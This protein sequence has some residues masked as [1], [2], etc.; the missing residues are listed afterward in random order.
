MRIG[1]FGGT[2]DPIHIGHIQLANNATKD[3]KLNK[4]F[5]VP[6]KIPPHKVS[7]NLLPV[8]QRLEMIS[9]AIKTNKAFSIS[10]YEINRKNTTYTYQTVKYFKNKYPNDEIFLLLGSDSLNDL[11]SWKHPEILVSLCKF[12]VA[13]RK[14]FS[15]FR[16]TN[17]FKNSSFTKKVVKNISSTDIRNKAKNKKLIRSKVPGMV[18]KYISKNSLYTT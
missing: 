6:A 18:G 16:N 15:P 5:F 17:F 13:K 11:N 9:L 10:K 4:I 12:I 2:F 14:T 3:F 7:R 8:K 1:I